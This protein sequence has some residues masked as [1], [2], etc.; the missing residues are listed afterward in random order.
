MAVVPCRLLRPRSRPLSARLVTCAV[1]PQTP[2]PM[3]T[4]AGME[5]VGEATTTAGTSKWATYACQQQT[6][7][8][9]DRTRVSTSRPSHRQPAPSQ[10]AP[11]WRR[12]KCRKTRHQRHT[13][14]ERAFSTRFR[15]RHKRHLQRRAVLDV[16]GV[17]EDA[18]GGRRSA[19]G[20]LL[21]LESL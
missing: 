20:T 16:V 21:R 7:T 19:R 4:T 14:Q 9:R 8:L 3:G 6:L 13:T 10:R 5:V 18:I 11:A 1:P 2:T 12:V 17:G 15:L